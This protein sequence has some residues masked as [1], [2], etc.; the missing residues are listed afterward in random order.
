MYKHFKNQGYNPELSSHQIYFIQRWGELLENTHIHYRKLLKPSIRSVLKESL[1]VI[2]YFKD[3]T[4]YEHNVFEILEEVIET[5][6]N[7]LVLKKVYSEDFNLVKSRIERFLSNRQ[8]FKELKSESDKYKQLNLPY[9]IITTLYN[10][11]DNADIPKIYSNYL[12]DE[13]GKS[14]LSFEIVDHLTELV[15]SELIYE[16]H[17]KQ[18]LFKWGNGVFITDPEPNFLKRIERIKELGK[19]NRREFDCFIPLKLPEGYNSLFSHRDGKITFHKNPETLGTSFI[20]ENDID[21]RYHQGLCE[22]FKTDKHISKIRLES[23]DEVAAINLAREELISTTKLFTLENKHKQYYPGNLSDAIVYD[24]NGNQINMNPHIEIYQHGLQ[25]S[26]NEKYIKINLSS[27]MNNKYQGLDQLLQWCRVIQDSPKETGLVA[28]WSLL[29]YL[30]VT[31]SFN[32]RQNIL[33]YATPY[34]CHFYLKS[35]AWRTRDI[36]KQS[37][38]QNLLLIEEV[39]KIFGDEA[40]DTSKNEV[41]LH[42]FIKFLATNKPKADEI[43]KDKILEQRYIGLIN[44]YLSLRGKKLWFGEYLDNLKKQVHS[45]F[46]RAYRLRN[47][48]AHQASMD[49]DFLDEIYDMIAFYLKL[50]IDDLLFTITS[51]PNNS[52][53]DLVLVKRESYEDYLVELINI[54]KID[55][56]DFKKLITTKSLLV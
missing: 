43:Y 10:K 1:R 51:Q 22:F 23:T 2:D 49:E 40:I 18:Y 25:I 4:L 16:G 8:A 33:D 56:V 34:I 30:F 52:V 12:K 9:T 54:D 26:N 14:N 29:E 31:E 32:K 27:K 46:L 37:N 21:E 41:K 50:I 3:Q 15:I 17:N 42:Y 53:H 19:K 20:E 48:L 35:L 39:K 36:L 44:R 24:F 28:M 13:L 7:N 38:D 11:L 6:K 45:D 47:I 5:L 55:N